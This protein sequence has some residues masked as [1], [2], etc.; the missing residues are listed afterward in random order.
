MK[1]IRKMYIY[2]PLTLVLLIFTLVA[3]ITQS[4]GREPIT[5]QNL[6]VKNIRAN[7]TSFR[8]VYMP[9]ILSGGGK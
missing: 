4:G 7:P 3:L 1:H 2:I 5:A 6:S 8:S 9:R